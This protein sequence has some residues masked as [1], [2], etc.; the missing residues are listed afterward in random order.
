MKKQTAT[1]GKKTARPAEV[2]WPDHARTLPLVLL[3]TTIGPIIGRAEKAPKSEF[4]TTFCLRLW[5]PAAIRMGFEPGQPGVTSQK[6]AVTF[7]PLALVETYIDLSSASPFG[8]S[9][10]PDAL[11]PA[12][13]QHFEKV[14][15]GEY[16]FN[17]IV[18]HVEQAKPHVADIEAPTEE[19]TPEPEPDLAIPDDESDVS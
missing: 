4:S 1:K 13:E 2:K 11:I 16:L 3:H 6:Y 12:Y 19:A 8:Q 10:M 14:A 9:I 7:Q 18:D 5:A 17:R 15:A